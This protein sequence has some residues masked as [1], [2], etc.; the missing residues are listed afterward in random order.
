MNEENGDLFIDTTDE[1]TRDQIQ[2]VKYET[3]CIHGVH[4]TVY[5]LYISESSVRNLLFNLD[6]K[7]RSRDV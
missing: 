1:E 7:N 6:I 2:N 3:V 5:I 4:D